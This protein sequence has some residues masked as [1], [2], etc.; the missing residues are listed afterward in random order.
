[1]ITIISS[2]NHCY[3]NAV[4]QSLRVC[5]H[6]RAALLELRVVFEKASF[7]DLM[8]WLTATVADRPLAVTR[9]T[10]DRAGPGR[11]DCVVVLRRTDLGRE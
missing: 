11:V 4:L 9:L 1:M 7:P 6:F 10:A 2:S 8:R 3:Q 5:P